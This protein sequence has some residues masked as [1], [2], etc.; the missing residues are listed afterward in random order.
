MAHRKF[1]TVVSSALLLALAACSASQEDEAGAGDLPETAAG[2]IGSPGAAT[3]PSGQ[4]ALVTVEGRIEVGAEC[5]LIRTPDGQIWA[6]S[7]EESDFRPGDDVR[8]TGEVMDASI[9]MQGEGTL[10]PRRI[11]AAEPPPETNAPTAD[12]LASSTAL[13]H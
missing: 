4:P 12:G 8:L 6:L 2:E 3:R 10:L 1:A 5:P 7:L 9:C 11:V 13:S